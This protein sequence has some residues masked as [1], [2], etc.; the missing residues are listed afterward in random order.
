MYAMAHPCSGYLRMAG[1]HRGRGYGHGGGGGGFGFTGGFGR[2]GRRASRGDVRAAV[3]LLLAEEPRNGYALM[4][5]IERRSGG[6]WRPSP[7]SIYPALQQLEDQG[8]IRM[9]EGGPG[10][11]FELTDAGHRLVEEHRDELGEPWAAATGGL[12]KEAFEVRELLSQVAAA[13]MQVIQAGTADQRAQA[14]TLLTETRRSLY[15]LLAEEED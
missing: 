15:R 10:R 2:G 7:G 12:P 8:F 11:T 6:V 9:Q 5:E 14:V 13:A 1:G 4:Q 3:V